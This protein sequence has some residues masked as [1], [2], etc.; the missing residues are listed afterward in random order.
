MQRN[1]VAVAYCKRGHGLIKINGTPIE[2]VQP[3]TIRV[4]VL[5]PVL[6]LGQARFAHVDI[7]VRVSGGGYVSQIYGT[8][9]HVLSYST[10]CAHYACLAIRQAICKALVAFTQKC[11]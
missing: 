10:F 2:F 11:T 3:Q 8:L 9:L 7:R 6:L 5:E 1:A 4:K